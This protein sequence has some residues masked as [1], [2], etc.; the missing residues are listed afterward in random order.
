MQINIDFC[1]N[2]YVFHLYFDNIETDVEKFNRATFHDF[3]K[4]MILP[5]KMLT[6]CRIY[7][8]KMVKS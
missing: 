7:D 4:Y 1:N 6:V 5:M 3:M 8:R 2:G